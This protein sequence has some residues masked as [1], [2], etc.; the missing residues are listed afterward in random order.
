MQYEQ[1]E[2]WKRS[3][4]LSVRVYQ[5]FSESR[6]YGFKDQIC[7]SG[8]SVPSNI[9][10]GLER[11]SNKEKSR[12]LSIAKGSVGELKTQ[13]MIA[14]E[15]NYL[16]KEESSYLSSECEQISKMLGAFINTLKD[17]S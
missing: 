8:L 7:R 11:E 12:F 17:R 3:F 16:S 6:D 14:K 5:L 13:V 10:E 2:V 15:I 4:F 1:L 9:A